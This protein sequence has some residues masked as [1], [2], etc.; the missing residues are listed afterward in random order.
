MFSSEER[1][2]RGTAEA[3]KTGVR[4]DGIGERM[5]S[6]GSRSGRWYE[7]FAGISR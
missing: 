4:G 7:C 1:D 6:D 5:A 2:E 3:G